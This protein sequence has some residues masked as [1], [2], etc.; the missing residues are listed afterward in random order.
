MK[1]V[2]IGVLSK[3]SG[4]PT[5]TLRYYEQVGLIRPVCRNGL[6]RQYSEETIVQLALIGLGKAAGFSLEDIGAMFDEDRNP[7]LARPTLLQRADELDRQ[8][9]RMTTMSR[10]LRHVAECPAPSHMECPRFRKLLRVVCPSV[11]LTDVLSQGAAK[12]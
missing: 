10:L 8:V 3:T 11:A 2:D 7:D 9:L 6:R 12:R 4:V 1:L 5:S